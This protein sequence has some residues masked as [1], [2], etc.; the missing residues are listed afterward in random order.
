MEGWEHYTP[1]ERDIGRTMVLKAGYEVERH[2]IPE[3]F[4]PSVYSILSVYY[5]YKM[6]GWPWSGGWGE[7]PAYLVDII[8]TLER[9]AG[10]HK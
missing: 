3:Y 10:K 4:T 7:Q 6:F 1:T 8:E 5:K 2:K 9:E